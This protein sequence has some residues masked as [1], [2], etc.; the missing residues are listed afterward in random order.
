VEEEGEALPEDSKFPLAAR[1]CT[2]PRM[3]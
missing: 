3:A 2:T 1:A